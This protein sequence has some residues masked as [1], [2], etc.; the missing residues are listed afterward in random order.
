MCA[1]THQALNLNALSWEQQAER[2]AAGNLV[3]I[4]L[5]SPANELILINC[6]LH[7]WPLS[8]V[9]S[10]SRESYAFRVGSPFPPI[11]DLQSWRNVAMEA[12][13]HAELL[14]QVCT[15]MQSMRPI[16][17]AL[18]ARRESECFYV[19]RWYSTTYDGALTIDSIV[20]VLILYCV[21]VLFAA[22]PTLVCE[23]VRGYRQRAARIAMQNYQMSSQDEPW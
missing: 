12:H 22:V 9:G 1:L 14:K 21:G 6:S 13:Y 5:E 23:L 7:Q 2:L 4:L 11:L 16:A 3:A 20:G 10:A 15:A 8:D 19:A 18:Q 17:C